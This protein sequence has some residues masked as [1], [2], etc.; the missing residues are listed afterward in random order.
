MKKGLIIAI[1][2]IALVMTSFVSA[3]IFIG[4]VN[5]IYNYGDE[6][7]LQV[8]LIPN[9]ALAAHLI[10]NII[11]GSSSANIFN[12]YYNL[13]AGQTQSVNVATNII[14]STLT[15]DSTDCYVQMV[16][17][18]EQQVP[19]FKVVSDVNDYLRLYV[20]VA[21]MLV[22]CFFIIGRL[23]SRI[24]ISQALKLGED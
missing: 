20:I 17:G 23:I 2:S 3:E 4:S 19:P 1:L 22:L 13:A 15:T 14:D 10:G 7:N 18:S 24:N 11:C 9:T 5:P 6:L 8:N 16:Y 21:L 12:N